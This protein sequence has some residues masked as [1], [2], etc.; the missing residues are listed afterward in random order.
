MSSHANAFRHSA[1]LALAALLSTP[2]LIAQTSTGAIEITL[3]DPSE[4]VIPG[5][6]VVISGAETG[7]VV[8][9]LATNA[10]GVAAAPL[11][12]PQVY[13]IAVSAAGFNKLLRN[14]IVL[15]VGETVNLRLRLEPGSTTESVT[16]VGQTPLLEERSGTLSH[17]V[18]QKQILDLPL[19]GRSY[20]QL[21]NLAAGAVPSRASRDGSFSAYGNNGLQN[22]FLLDGAR[23]VNYLRGLDNLSRDVL[24]PPLDALSE[25]NVQLSNY[26][27][28]FGASAGGVVNAITRSGTNSLHGSGYDFLRNDNFDAADFFAPAGA[29]PLLVR[30]QY[31]GS[32]GGPIARNRSWFFGAYEGTHIRNEDTTV[33]TVPDLTTRQGDFSATPIFDP[34]STARNPAGAGYVRTQFPGNVI[35]ASRMDPLGR[36]IM[37]RYP[38]PNAFGLANNYVRNSPMLQSN[39]NAV[40][41]GDVQVTPADTMFGRLA[42]TRFKLSGQPGLPP[43]AQTP[44]DRFINSWGVGYGYTRT[45]SPRLVNELRFAWTRMTMNQD[46]TLPRDEIIPGMLDPKV[47]SS[48]P[49][50]NVTGFAAIGAQAVTNNVPMTKSSAVWA[51]S[52]NVSKSIDRHMLKFGADV[53]FIR[54]G[55]FATMRGRGT[56]GFTGVFSQN[57]QG[58]PRTGSAAADLLLGA[59]NALDTGTTM[60]SRERAPCIGLYFQ[61]EWSVTRA[62]TVTL[63]MRYELFYPYI[64][65]DNRMANLILDP[66]DALFGSFIIAGDSRKPRSLL[67]LDKNNWGPRVGL[68]WRVPGVSN[69]VIRSS[70]GVF[71]A[72]DTGLGVIGRPTGNPPFYGYGSVSVISDQLFPSTGYVLS[73]SVPVPRSQPIDPKKFVLDSASTAPL[74]SWH[75]RYTTPYTQQWNVNIQKQLPWSMVWQTSYVG[76]VGVHIWGSAEGN[77]PLANGP[78]SPND[79]R[80]LARITRA[81]V[82][83]FSPW[84]RSLYHGMSSRLEKRFASSLSFVTSFTYGRAIDLQNLGLNVG[85]AAGDSVQNSY[86]R[87][88]Q[89][90]PADN[91]VPLRLAFSGVWDLPFGSGRRLAPRGPLAVLAGGW[92]LSAIYQ[93]Q[94]GPPFSVMSS[95]DNANSGTS[96][97]PNRVCSGR[98]PSPTIRRWYD[99]SCFVTPPQYQF[100]NSGRNILYGPGSNNIDLA[101]HRSFVLPL[102]RR[103]T[104]DFRA[105]A[106]NL[107][108]HPQFGVPGTTVGVAAAGVISSTSQANRQLQLGLRLAF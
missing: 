7:N 22:A 72:Q 98:L 33:S 60:E 78:G 49:Q 55:T 92:R 93:A 69:L 66:A 9:T 103:T 32:L 38:I 101:L 75:Q 62:L 36:K 96:N 91:H 54:P 26:S 3:I 47:R 80:P 42:L 15:R 1:L 13:N 68:A 44:V 48:I 107:A 58:R 76:N 87:K 31:G 35:P 2:I 43:P 95:F 53:Q 21:A 25:F 16:V 99:T 4:A 52:D 6:E 18:E 29:K 19:N 100:G 57:P 56:F 64:E 89:R 50:F 27:A 17:V 40:T 45:F 37:D 12:P 28:E 39:R 23:N 11:L 51:V 83:L 85:S 73:S 24:R 70:Y 67:A 105:E 74:V 94:S 34:F 20:L 81:S 46:A 63:G 82:G 97:R 77:Q 65:T 84:N 30:N 90:G 102:E 41:R 106:F 86:D 5:A 108:N 59:A 79:R 104:L 14:G 10:V 71:F 61:D 8:R 88:S